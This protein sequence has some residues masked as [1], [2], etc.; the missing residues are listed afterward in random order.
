[1]KTRLLLVLALIALATPVAWADTLNSGASWNPWSSPTQRNS[2]PFSGTPFWDNVSNDGNP[3]VTGGNNC[4]VG[5]WV[6]GTGNCSVTGFYAGSP[7][8]TGD[9][10][11]DGTASI[12]FTAD[13]ATNAVTAAVGVSA[14][15]ATTEFGWFSTTDPT[16]HHAIISGGAM[17]STTTFSVPS[18]DYGFYLSVIDPRPGQLVPSA[19]YYSNTTDG[20]NRSHFALFDLGAGHYV[21]GIEDKQ[22]D[23]SG[24]IPNWS[25]YDYND[26]VI[27]LTSTPVPEPGSALLLGMGLLGGAAML[28]KRGKKQASL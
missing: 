5:F 16:T 19:T 17:G 20:L 27:E 26:L 14:L 15:S 2:V 12:L 3:K 4:N 1:M 9:F 11:G 8:T 7:R 23:L 21:L 6:S 24:K 18:G 10:L 13:G 22:G 25:D 28:R